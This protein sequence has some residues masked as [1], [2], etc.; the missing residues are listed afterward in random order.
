MAGARWWIVQAIRSV[1]SHVR[2]TVVSDTY[3]VEVTDTNGP[4]FFV[5]VQGAEGDLAAT[6]QLVARIE[7]AAREGVAQHMRFGV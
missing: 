7:E 1:A 4:V 3:E 2:A 5:L 6:R